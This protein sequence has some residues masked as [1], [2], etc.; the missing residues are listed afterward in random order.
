[1]P[2][3]V[4]RDLGATLAA[5]R[6]RARM[7][8]RELSRVSDV[9]YTQI[10]DLE[11]GTGGNPSPL[12]LRALAKGLA[13]DAFLTEGYEPIRADAFYRQLMDAAGYL[14]GL[15]VESPPQDGPQEVT[16]DAVVQFL[17]SRAGDATLAANLAQLAHRYPDLSPDEQTVVRHLVGTWVNGS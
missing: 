12:T 14:R 7:S 2:R 8:Q 11:R 4:P 15:P 1:M 17:S 13:T 6:Q 5:I 9:S 10:G 3:D 16:E